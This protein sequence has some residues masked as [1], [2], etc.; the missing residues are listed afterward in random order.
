MKVIDLSCSARPNN[1]WYIDYLAYQASTPRNWIE[2]QLEPNGYPTAGMSIW[3][4]IICLDGA[5]ERMNHQIKFCG[6]PYHATRNILA[7]AEERF[8]RLTVAEAG[9]K[10]TVR[11]LGNWQ[12][13]VIFG[14]E[15]PAAAID[16]VA[17]VTRVCTSI[18]A[19]EALPWTCQFH[20]R[21][22]LGMS[23]G[24]AFSGLLATY[25]DQVCWIEHTPQESGWGS[26][27]QIMQLASLPA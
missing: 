16:L 21:A 4:V 13:G 18:N 9:V 6:K 1:D 14:Y 22:G 27:R 15:T 7:P 20:V 19:A 11:V 17:S 25:R 24:E 5:P 2:C 10:P 3:W 8:R 12:D 26:I 23:V